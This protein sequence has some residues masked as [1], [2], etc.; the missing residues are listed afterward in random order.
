MAQ[1]RWQKRTWELAV[2]LD[3]SAKSKQREYNCHLEQIHSQALHACMSCSF[4]KL[5]F[6]AL[7]TADWFLHQA[8]PH[9][10]CQSQLSPLLKAHVPHAV[11]RWECLAAAQAASPP[12]PAITAAAV[13]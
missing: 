1:K 10:T 8:A 12:V 11:T 3:C 9:P 4:T 7:F 2:R 6:S 13:V 5:G